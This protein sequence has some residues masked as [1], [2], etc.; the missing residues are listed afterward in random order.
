MF[1]LPLFVG[2]DYHTNMIQ[3]CVMALV[4]KAWNEA[5]GIFA[6]DASA[7]KL[8]I[9]KAKRE[10]PNLWN[11][12]VDSDTNVLVNKLVSH[13]LET[14]PDDERFIVGIQLAS[15]DRY[16]EGGRIRVAYVPSDQIDLFLELSQKEQK[17]MAL[18]ILDGK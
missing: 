14:Y 11:E 16:E 18:N 1:N 4:N 8:E 7:L 9:S 12:F 17:A 13:K 15:D 2:I 6:D 10:L 3:V 5:I